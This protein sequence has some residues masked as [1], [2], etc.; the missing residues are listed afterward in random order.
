M[1][2]VEI[3]T[4]NYQEEK[5]KATKRVIF[6]VM[7]SLAL[8]IGLQ[9]ASHAAAT[10]M[11]LFLTDG[12]TTIIVDDNDGVHD[13]NPAVGFISFTGPVAVSYTHLT[14]PTN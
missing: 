13:S 14:L 7:V 9:S 11:E 1:L 5:M 8:L 4:L 2:R 6:S 10:P 12:S 3:G